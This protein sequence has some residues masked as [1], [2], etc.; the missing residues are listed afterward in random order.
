AFLPY[1]FLPHSFLR[2]PGRHD[3]ASLRQGRRP[4]LDLRGRHGRHLLR[5][6]DHGEEPDPA[7]P[8]RGRPLHPDRHR[9][10]LFGL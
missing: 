9:P 5:D 4:L 7:H 8:D 3:P 10:V 6:D 1:R 2:R